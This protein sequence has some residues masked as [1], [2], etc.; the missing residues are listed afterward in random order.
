TRSESTRT[1]R[2]TLSEVVEEPVPAPDVA[3]IEFDESTVDELAVAA[4][5]VGA[6][7]VDAQMRADIADQWSWASSAA[8]IPQI[9]DLTIPLLESLPQSRLRVAL[10][11]R[12]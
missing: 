6:P 8:R 2:T 4:S 9:S 5:A 3:D 11:H 7:T 10:T 12:S 1:P